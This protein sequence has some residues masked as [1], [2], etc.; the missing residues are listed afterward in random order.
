MRLGLESDS[1]TRN[2]GRVRGKAAGVLAGDY[3][4]CVAAMVLVGSGAA[5]DP[6]ALHLF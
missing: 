4:D 5:P 6:R 1:Q 3:L 2:G